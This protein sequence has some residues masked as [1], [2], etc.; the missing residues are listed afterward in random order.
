MLKAVAING[1]PRK[2]KGNTAMILA[3]VIQGMRGAGADVEVFYT[4]N[5]KLKPCIGEMKCWWETPGD[6]HIKDG[7]QQVYPKLREADI[8]IL[9]TPVYIP[10]PGEMQIF[11]NR[12]CPLVIPLLETREGRTRARLRDNVKLRKVLLVSTGGWWEK[13]NLDTVVRIAKEL[14]ED[15]S[16]EFTGAVLRPH[17]FLMKKKG[18]L[19]EDGQSVLDAARKAGHELVKDGRPDE[20]TLE[21]ISRPLISREELLKRYNAAVQQITRK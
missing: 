14:A 18:E 20:A 19:T 8:L 11:I 7:M 1:S 9:A 2:D 5:L 21:T 16:V 6:C 15:M 10:L 13:E 12:L 4:K 3:A 17:A